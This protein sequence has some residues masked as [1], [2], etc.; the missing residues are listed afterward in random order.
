MPV[1]VTGMQEF[2]QDLKNLMGMVSSKEI[3]DAVDE[4]WS[5]VTD[6]MVMNIASFGKKGSLIDTG[7]MINQKSSLT[8][9]GMTFNNGYPYIYSNSGIFK[10]DSAMAVFGKNASKDMPASMYAFWL[11]FG[12]Q[13]HS[14]D[15]GDRAYNEK[16]SNAKSVDA[17]DSDNITAGIT[18]TNFISR[19]FDMKSEAAFSKIEYNLGK[20]TDKYIK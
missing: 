7:L 3:V 9:T 13:P 15:S 12:T 11:E 2:N 17:K 14:L 19:A 6:Q 1:K 18:A 10:S 8:H 5:I 20:L 4:G 16:R